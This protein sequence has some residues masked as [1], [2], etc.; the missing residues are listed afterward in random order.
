MI[1][2]DRGFCLVH[3]MYKE[4]GVDYEISKGLCTKQISHVSGVC[5]KTLV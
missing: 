4:L 2:N 1:F 5:L 3:F